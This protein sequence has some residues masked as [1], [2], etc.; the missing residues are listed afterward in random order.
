MTK[1]TSVVENCAYGTKSG[2][3][4]KMNKQINPFK[5]LPKK[6]LHGL[7]SV[8]LQR[9]PLISSHQTKQN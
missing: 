8:W 4:V 2:K 3:H 9:I 1:T 7:G 6:V 5:N